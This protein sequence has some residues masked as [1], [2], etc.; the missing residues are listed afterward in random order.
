LGKGKLGGISEQRQN[1]AYSILI[2]V[3]SYQFASPVQ[4]IKTQDLMFTQYTFERF[5]EIGP[6]PMLTGMATCTLKAKY[7]TKNL[8]SDDSV[9]HTHVILCHAKNGKEIYYL[10][11]DEPGAPPASEA[12]ASNASVPAPLA[13]P[14]V[15]SGPSGP[16]V[17]VGNQDESFMS[18]RDAEV[19]APMDFA[20]VTGWKVCMS[21]PCFQGSY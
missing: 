11:K 6:S 21:L 7:D 15:A 4:W 8:D 3:L 1:L 20:I 12:P 9:S 17:S 10:F 14:V 16:A 13:T 18:V 19:K 2:E 5:I